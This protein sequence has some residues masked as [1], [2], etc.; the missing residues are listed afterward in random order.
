M[1]QFDKLVEDKVQILINGGITQ[2]TDEE[3][4]KSYKKD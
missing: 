2:I 1:T 4:K 3:V